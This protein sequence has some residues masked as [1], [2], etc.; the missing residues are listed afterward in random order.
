MAK[1]ASGER[2]RVR[3]DFPPGHM[4]T[5]VYIR[6][7]VG[8]VTRRLGDFGNPERLA[9]RLKGPKRTLYEVRFR[10]VDVWPDYHGAAHDCLDIDLY[11]HWLQRCEG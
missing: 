11:D 7:K 4:R 5:P 2:V 10:Q 8:V 3:E 6:G 1:L 9:L